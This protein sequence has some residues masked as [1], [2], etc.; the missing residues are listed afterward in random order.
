MDTGLDWVAGDKI[1][2]APTA[3]QHRNSDYAEV[4]AYDS[5]TGAVTLKAALAYYHF[6]AAA[7]LKDS[8]SGLDMRGEVILLTRNIHVRGDDSNTWAAQIAT[9]DTVEFDGTKRTGSMILDS[10]EVSRCGQENTIKA[11]V[12]FENAKKAT[13]S[14][15]VDSVLHDGDAEGLFIKSSNNI[16]VEKTSIVGFRPIGVNIMTATNLTMKNLFVG[17]IVKR[18]LNF[19]GMVLDKEACI[20]F[21]AFNPGDKCPSST[22]QDSRVAG[23]EYAGYTTVGNDC[24]S[25][26]EKFKNNVAHSIKGVGAII[27]VDP[28]SANQGT[29]YEAA[30][31][32][33]Y[34]CSM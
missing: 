13:T 20:S 34:K 32:M 22:L 14:K 10:V 17:N 33:A 9:T 1:M 15:I 27:G 29:C 19:L 23:C 25:T 24:G 3:I 6:G 26:G 16:T 11:C 31:F 8:F 12:R 28:D 30:N 21:C 7:T 5:A 18:E 2:F 4:A